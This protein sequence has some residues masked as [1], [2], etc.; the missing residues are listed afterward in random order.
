MSKV[1]FELVSPDRLLF[2]QEAEMIVVPGS[3]G[4]FGVLAG[5]APLVSTLKSGVV[6]VYPELGDKPLRV[7]IR[8]GFAEVGNTAL[9][10][11]AEEAIDLAEVDRPDLERRMRD[12]EEDIRDASDDQ[13]R[14]AAQSRYDELQELFQQLDQG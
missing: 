13:A 10:I 11:L 9:T 6:E 4:L 8:G 7:F 5:H 2:S 3:E 1:F 12:G 14:N